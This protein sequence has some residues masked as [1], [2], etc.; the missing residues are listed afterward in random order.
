MADLT[1]SVNVSSLQ[2]QRDGV[3]TDVVQALD[4]SGLPAPTLE[5]ELTESLLI[6]DSS[7]AACL[8]RLRRRGVSFAIDDFGIGYSNL[9]YL[10]RFEVA[11]LKIDQSFVRRLTDDVHDEAIV[12]AIVQM[13][14]SL[15][16]LTVAEGVE[17]ESTMARLMEMGCHEGQGFHWA[18]AMPAGE[19]LEF[20]RK[21]RWMN[22]MPGRHLRT[23]PPAHAVGR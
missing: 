4:D 17:S 23:A 7:V 6:Q 2:F 19:F 20:V 13:G 22:Q 18:P 14:T 12:R 8:R 9:A 3:E 5:L 10:K 21:C 15:S 16:L 11:R 1:I